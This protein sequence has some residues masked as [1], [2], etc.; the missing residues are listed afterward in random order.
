MACWTTINC[1]PPDSLPSSSH[2]EEDEMPLFLD[3]HI[4]PEGATAESVAAAHARDL[5]QFQ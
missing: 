3:S 1:L 4:L 2:P 5:V